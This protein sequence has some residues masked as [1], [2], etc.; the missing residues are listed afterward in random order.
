MTNT[1]KTP[2]Q[3]EELSQR[4]KELEE[5]NAQQKATIKWYEEQFRLM[6]QNVLPPRVKRLLITK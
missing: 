5:V 3:T 6:Q 4:V 1:T 2:N